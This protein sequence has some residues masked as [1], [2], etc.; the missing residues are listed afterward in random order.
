M[1]LNKKK[2]QDNKKFKSKQVMIIKQEIVEKSSGAR[3]QKNKLEFNV[4][5]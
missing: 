5:H 3:Y 1:L 2:K 4:S